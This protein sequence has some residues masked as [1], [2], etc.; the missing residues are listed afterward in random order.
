MKHSRNRYSWVVWTLLITLTLASCYKFARIAAPKTVDPNTA[1]EGR[2]VAINDGNNGEQTGYSVF[3]IRVPRNWEVTVGDNAY[4]QYGPEGVKNELGEDINMTARMV[5][6]VTLSDLYNTSNPKEGFEWIAFRTEHINRRSLVQGTGCDSIVFNY[7]VL[8]DGVAGTYELDYIMGSIEANEDNPSVI[9]NYATNLNDFLGSDLCRV[10]TEHAIYQAGGT[11]DFNTVSPEFKTTVTVKEGGTPVSKDPTL[12]LTAST[13]EAG[14]STTIQYTN[15]PQGGTVKLYKQASMLAMSAACTIEGSGRRNSG[16]FTVEGLEPGVYHVKALRGNGAALDGCQEAL[17]T[18]KSY[19]D[20]ALASGHKVMVIGEPNILAPTQ[21]KAAG[22]AYEAAR[23]LNAALCAEAPAIFAALID[24]AIAYKPEAVLIAGGLTMDGGKES[25]AFLAAMLKRLTDAGIKVCVVPGDQDINNPTSSCYD[26]D[27]A[28]RVANISATEF[29]TLY[30]PFGYA[31]AVMRDENSLSY[32]SYINDNLAVIALDG[33]EYNYTETDSVANESGHLS[34]A[35]VEW[36]KQAASTAA[37]TQRQVVALVHHIVGAPFIGYGTLGNMLNNNDK[38]D[39]I[40]SILGSA[41]SEGEGEGEATPAYELGTTDI[42]QALSSAGIMTIFTGE[43]NGLDIAGITIDGGST[44]LQV[45]TPSAVAFDCPFR[46]V[47]INE[48]SFEL[49]TRF[50]INLPAAAGMSFEEYAYY[51]TKY[52]WEAYINNVCAQN[53]E[54]INAF[55]QTNFTFE[56]EEGGI[57]VNAFFSLPTTPQEM[58]TLLLNSIIPPLVETIVTFA[59]GNESLKESQKLVDDFLAGIDN[60]F[61]GLNTLPSIITPMLKEGFA[62]AGLDLDAMVNA[63]VGS[64]A[65]D[66]ND[67]YGTVVNDL[68]LNIPFV[69]TGIDNLKGDR[70]GVCYDLQGRR[71][72]QPAKGLYIMDGQK[73]F[74]K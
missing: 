62:E 60:L 43:A 57:D 4:Q 30:A 3:A 28:T 31:D 63:V 14:G 46:L 9:E 55:L 64:I 10:S 49:E 66:V 54:Q 42:Q 18:V 65:Y 33:C 68:Y 23:G 48:E 47:G 8:N 74:V 71:I 59:D 13:I 26:G 24:S 20:K 5:Y 12:T 34:P 19:T 40:S 52:G 39:L 73:V 44:L 53:W 70:E 50:N 15:L 11:N 29:A 21:L 1:F 51:R 58:A 38:I 17:L 37:G 45:N 6:S 22:T 7:T 41:E 16:S 2:I 32:L 69:R 72:A 67:E 56:V 25:H 27:N 61:G 36:M 35:T